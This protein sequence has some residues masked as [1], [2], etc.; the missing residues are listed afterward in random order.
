MGDK[1]IRIYCERIHRLHSK[2]L[3]HGVLRPAGLLLVIHISKLRR[4]YARGAVGERSVF[5]SSRR[6]RGGMLSYNN[7]KYPDEKSY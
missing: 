1:G 2:V 6:P 5:V 7:E 3:G 4:S